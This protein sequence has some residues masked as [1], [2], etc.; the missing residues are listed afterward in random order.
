MLLVVGGIGFVAKYFMNR[1]FRLAY[2]ELFFLDLAF[3]L[4]SRLLARCRRLQ[5]SV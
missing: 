3:M 5:S 1:Y 2:G 4:Q